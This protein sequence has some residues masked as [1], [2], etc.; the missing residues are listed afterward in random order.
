[1][2]F[3][4]LTYLGLIV[5]ALPA[6]LGALLIFNCVNPM[7]LAFVTQF[8]VVNQSGEPVHVTPIGTTESGRTAALPQY[9]ARLPAL[10]A[11]RDANHPIPAGGTLTIRYDWDDINFTELRVRGADGVER[12]FPTDPLPTTR[13]YYANRQGQYVI[14][15]LKTLPPATTPYVS[16]TARRNLVSAIGVGGVIV[17]VTLCGQ[18][19]RL[20]RRRPPTPQ[21]TQSP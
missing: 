4:R 14:P 20:N 19:W 11:L 8:D 10:P 2:W 13:G 18:L 16:F 1:M 3:R 6:L 5:T 12:V 15:P 21:I 9:A 17:F 7:T